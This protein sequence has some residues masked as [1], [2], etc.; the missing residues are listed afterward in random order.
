[1]STYTAKTKGTGYEGVVK[2]L[3]IL[4]GDLMHLQLSGETWQLTSEAAEVGWYLVNGVA[5]SPEE[6]EKVKNNYLPP[7]LELP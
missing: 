7:P 3:E 1:M 6:F 4:E 2:I 5:M